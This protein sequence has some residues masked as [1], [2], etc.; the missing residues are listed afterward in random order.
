MRIEELR[1]DREPLTSQCFRDKQ[2]CSR[3]DGGYCSTYA[4]PEQ[5]WRLGDCPM[6]DTVLCTAPVAETKK[7]G[8]TKF[9]RNRRS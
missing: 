5:K 2:P 6:A 7:P 8:R 1:N 9:R 3:A 4:Y